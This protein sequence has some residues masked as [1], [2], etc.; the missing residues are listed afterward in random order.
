MEREILLNLFIII[1]FLTV[2]IDGHLYAIHKLLTNKYI[3]T[4]IFDQISFGDK[5]KH[6][7]LLKNASKWH[8]N[9][10]K[11]NKNN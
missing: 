2:D 11:I 9:Q 5:H 4:W 8:N 6:D 3:D 7:S 10:W 1:I